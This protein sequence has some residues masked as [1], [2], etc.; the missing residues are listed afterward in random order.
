MHCFNVVMYFKSSNEKNLN[1][2]T[3]NTWMSVFDD[4]DSRN[5]NVYGLLVEETSM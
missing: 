5:D 4:F 1:L 3:L 2:V